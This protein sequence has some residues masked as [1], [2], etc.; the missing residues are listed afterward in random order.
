VGCR[1]LSWAGFFSF[2]GD[3]SVKSGSHVHT[4]ASLLTAFM[5]V[6]Q[7]VHSQ[8]VKHVLVK[9]IWRVPAGQVPPLT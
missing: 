4:A 3:E 6:T 5:Q 8:V 9:R 7:V 1:I 2:L